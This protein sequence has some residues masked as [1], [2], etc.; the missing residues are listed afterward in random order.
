MENGIS[1]VQC[2]RDISKYFKEAKEEKTIRD[3]E[4]AND[5]VEMYRDIDYF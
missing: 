1:Q 5:F 4:F 3:E 2:Q